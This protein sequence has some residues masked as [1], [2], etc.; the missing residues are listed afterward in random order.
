M[1]NLL[2]R[3]NNQLNNHAEEISETTNSYKFP[4]KTGRKIEF[5]FVFLFS[6]SRKFSGNFFSST[7]IMGGER[8][9]Q[10]VPESYL[11]G[12]NTDLNWLGSKPISVSHLLRLTRVE[13]DVN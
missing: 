6:Q 11:F 12:E 1:G 7:F 8:F 3:L 2:S 4:P 5:S 10:T 13:P 9:D